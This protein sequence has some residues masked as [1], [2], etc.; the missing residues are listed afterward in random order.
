MKGSYTTKK[1]NSPDSFCTIKGCTARNRSRITPQYG[2]EKPLL[3]GSQTTRENQQGRKKRT[4]RQHKPWEMRRGENQRR[5][6][7]SQFWD[8]E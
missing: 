3:Y 8:E 5:G 4:V 6:F 2:F 1:L 7:D